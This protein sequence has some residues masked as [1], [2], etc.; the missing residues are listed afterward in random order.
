MAVS[1]IGRGNW[2]TWGKPPPCRKLLTNFIS[3]VVSSTPCHERDLNSQLFSI[4]PAIVLKNN[5][6][7]NYSQNEI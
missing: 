3:Y 2:S 5:F 6:E 7:L 1:F 4:S